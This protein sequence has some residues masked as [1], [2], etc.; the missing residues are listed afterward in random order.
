MAWNTVLDLSLPQIKSWVFTKTNIG[1]WF[2]DAFIH[3]SHT[4]ALTIT[5]SP[6]QQGSTITDF[7]YVQP[8][9][10]SMAIGMSDAA[11][12]FIP[13]QFMEHGPSRSVTAYQVLRSLQDQRV[14]IQVYTRLGLYQ[15]MLVASITANEDNTTHTGLQVT[16]DLQEV[17]VAT[18]STVK[19][20]SAP[21][22]TSAASRGK[23]QPAAPSTKQQSILN[24]LL[25]IA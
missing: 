5:S 10:L 25:G 22:V 18:I 4:S 11:T 1:G 9:T 20:S 23:Q 6:V 7:A 21:H 8:R 19:I 24:L 12:S 16:V 14:P 3:M 2:F 17:L 13:G 15:N